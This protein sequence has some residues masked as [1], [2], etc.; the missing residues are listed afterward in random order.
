V[1]AWVLTGRGIESLAQVARPEPQPGPG[2]VLVRVHAV[3]LNHRDLGLARRGM[4]SPVVPTSDGAGVVVGLGPGVTGWQTGDR[5]M[6]NFFQT[7][8]DGSWHPRYGSSALG[9]AIDGML[10][11]LV[12]LEQDAI[13]AVPHGWTFEE[14]ATLPCAGVTAWNALYGDRVVRAG[15]LVVVQGS[16]GVSVFALQLAV[17][18][19]AEVAATS[20][21]DRK[22]D[23]LVQ[24]GA[25]VGVNYRSSPD[26]A[27][28]MR[29]RAGRAADHVVEVTGQLDFSLQV[30]AS[31]GTVT[32]I[33]TTLGTDGPGVEIHPALILQKCVTIRGVYVGSTTMLSDLARAMTVAGLRPVIHSTFHFD[34]AVDAY[35]ALLRAD[36]IGKIVITYPTPQ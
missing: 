5:V 30:A 26:W 11:E 23:A 16:G 31:N 7:W 2:Q 9:G 21:S 1:I 35:R 36:H 6:A 14:A 3:S 18:A 27:A 34:K 32:V 10:A 33:G 22:L 15:D 12:V 13:V 17:A 24:L 19:G 29:T 4:S 28:E 20:S 25:S 8:V